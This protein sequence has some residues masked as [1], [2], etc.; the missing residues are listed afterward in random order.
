MDVFSFLACID[1]Q[2]N[3]VITLIALTPYLA[4]GSV[5]QSPSLFPD[6]LEEGM[7]QH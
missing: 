1:L 5:E 6:S 4:M 7:S 2:A 3:V